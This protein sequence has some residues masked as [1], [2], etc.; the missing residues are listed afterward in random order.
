MATVAH[1]QKRGGLWKWLVLAGKVDAGG[2][3][4]WVGCAANLADRHRIST[5]MGDNR[6]A[7]PEIV[8]LVALD[9]P[10]AQ[11]TSQPGAPVLGVRQAMRE[12]STVQ[13]VERGDADGVRRHVR[14]VVE[15][16]FKFE[17][18]EAWCVGGD[19]LPEK[20]HQVARVGGAGHG[21]QPPVRA[22]CLRKRQ[23]TDA[24]IG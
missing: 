6:L 17:L 7:P 8:P 10:D 5:G 24:V 19:V 15:H 18:Y 4:V 21:R 20:L 9:E 22:G 3:R 1:K 2:N 11:R 16:G 23:A 12:R 13:V 14:L